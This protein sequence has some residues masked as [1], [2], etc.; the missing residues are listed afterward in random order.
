[1]DPREMQERTKRFAVGVINFSE[2]LP[3]KRS[4][5]VLARQLISS[6]SSIGANYRE[7]CRAESRHDFVHKVGIAAKE[8]AETEYWLELLSETNPPSNAVTLLLQE[9]DQIL[10]ILIASGRTAR[11]KRT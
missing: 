10:R 1:M 6:A 7:A 3:R 8:A 4:N 5:D 2:S 9:S 11:Q